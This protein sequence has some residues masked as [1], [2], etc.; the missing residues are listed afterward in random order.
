MEDITLLEQNLNI[1]SAIVI[2]VVTGFIMNSVAT[3]EMALIWE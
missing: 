2:G 1:L 3:D